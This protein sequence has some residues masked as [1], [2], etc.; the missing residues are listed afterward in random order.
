LGGWYHASKF[1]LEAVSDAL[2]NEVR[3]FG[4][5]VIVVEPGAVAS[6][7]SG[8]A[9]DEAERC[10]GAGPYGPMVAKFRAWQ[11]NTDRAE[12]PPSVIRDLVV[13]ARKAP[14]P[15]TRYVGGGSAEQLIALRRQLSD[16]QFDDVVTDNLQLVRPAIAPK[17]VGVPHGGNC[18]GFDVSRSPQRI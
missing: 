3:Q 11:T 9:A 12:P 2:R 5:D 10:S 14:E 6:A 1:A 13:T 7:W 8:I 4:I 18:R 17:I 15:E 16:R